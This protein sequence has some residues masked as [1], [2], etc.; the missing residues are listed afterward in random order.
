MSSVPD[1][2]ESRSAAAPVAAKRMGAYRRS[3]SMEQRQK[4]KDDQVNSN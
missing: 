4:E 3:L 1:D 2:L